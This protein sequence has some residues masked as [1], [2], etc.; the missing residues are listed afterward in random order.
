M[1]SG[2]TIK[3]SVPKSIDVAVPS[4][5]ATDDNIDERVA[6]TDCTHVGRGGTLGLTQ[7]TV[8]PIPWP[9]KCPNPGPIQGP[10]QNPT[11]AARNNRGFLV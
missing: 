6:I 2:A 1:V 4:V 3:V 11:V 9:H 5:L 8:I 10:N 7:C